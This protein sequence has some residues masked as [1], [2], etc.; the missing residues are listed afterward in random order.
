MKVRTVQP[1]V[2][3]APQDQRLF[4]N[5]HSRN[6]QEDNDAKDDDELLNVTMTFLFL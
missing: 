2:N 5:D 6:D 1:G 4:F 3:Y